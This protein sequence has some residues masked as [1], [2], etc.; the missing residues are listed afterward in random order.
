VIKAC[1]LLFKVDLTFHYAKFAFQVLL[2]NFPGWQPS[3]SKHFYWAEMI[4][5]NLPGYAI[6]GLS[7]GE[8]KQQ[9]WKVVS[10]CTDE[11]PHDKPR[12][13]MGVGCLLLLLFVIIIIITITI[14][15]I[16]LGTPPTWLFAPHSAWICMT[17]YFPPER[18]Y[19]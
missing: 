9:F 8:D 18:L 4:K 14:I 10:L 1:S 16:L 6:G 3:G 17:A 2:V 11:L 19:Y 12:Y 5:R 13:C 15:N 7:G